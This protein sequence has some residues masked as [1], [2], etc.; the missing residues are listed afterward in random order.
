MRR[1]RRARNRAETKRIHNGDRPRAHRKNVAQNAANTGRRALKRFDI[2]RVVVRFDLERDHPAAA[3]P[4]DPGILTRALHHVLA[5][6]GQLL[7]VNARTLV[8]AVFAPHDAENAQL[9]IARLAAQQA[10]DLVELGGGELVLDDQ[11]RCNFHLEST[12]MELRIDSKM[13]MPSVEPISGSQARSG[14]GI[15]PITLRSRFR[16]PAMDR[17]DPF[18]FST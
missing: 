2:A 9:G 14:C 1:F 7:Q 15:M 17:A 4:D 5:R 6:G 3:D 13:P 10:D 12:G 18:G 11:L 8:R 16:M